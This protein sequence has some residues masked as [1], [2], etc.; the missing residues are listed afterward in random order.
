MR[1]TSES[2]VH[3]EWARCARLIDIIETELEPDEFDWFMRLARGRL[4]AALITRQR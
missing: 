2:R 3:Y 1:V 4:E